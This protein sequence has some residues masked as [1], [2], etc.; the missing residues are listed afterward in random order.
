MQAVET[1]WNSSYSCLVSIVDNQ[2]AI[3]LVAISNKKTPPLSEE[4]VEAMKS[5][6]DVLRPVERTSQLLE[7]RSECISS[8]LPAY[9]A[10]RTSLALNTPAVSEVDHFREEIKNGLEKR[11]AD[12]QHAK[13]LVL[14]TCLDPR[15]KLQVHTPS[16]RPMVKVMLQCELAAGTEATQLQPASPPPL[17]SHSA[18]DPIA[19]YVASSLPVE[20]SPPRNTRHD[21]ELEEYLKEPILPR[22][23]DPLD[24]WRTS[25]YHALRMLARRYLSA[26]PS[27]AESERHFSTMGAIY[28]PN[29]AKLSGDHAKHLL[30]LH[31][32]M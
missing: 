19:S 22:S 26:P 25:K 4:D 31:H 10:M 7:S 13:Y 8:V 6:V 18:D 32:H 28:K 20:H 1:R 3:R 24:Y 23:Y 9:Y 2:Q 15:Y 30:F 17:P 5:I 21:E 11:M 27:S 16:E 12:F 14:A 29:R